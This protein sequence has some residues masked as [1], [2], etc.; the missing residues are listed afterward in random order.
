MS[1]SHPTPFSSHTTISICP[2]PSN[3]ALVRAHADRQ[4]G[5]RRR[6]WNQARDLVRP[7]LVSLSPVLSSLQCAAHTS[8]NP[9]KRKDAKAPSAEDIAEWK[10]PLDECVGE[11]QKLETAVQV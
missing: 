4:G 10:E 7:H 11:V 5:A 2:Q 1:R 6:L 9:V 3:Q 8:S